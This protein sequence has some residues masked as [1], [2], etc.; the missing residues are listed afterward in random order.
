[1]PKGPAKEISSKSQS[2]HT[3]SKFQYQQANYLFANNSYSQSYLSK[4]QASEVN[5]SGKSGQQLAEMQRTGNAF[6]YGS[7]SGAGVMGGLQQAPSMPYLV[8][9]AAHEAYSFAPQNVRPAGGRQHVQVAAMGQ[10]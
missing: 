6:A 5:K 9:K 4:A 10:K 1:M 7:A 2:P 3:S 8:Q